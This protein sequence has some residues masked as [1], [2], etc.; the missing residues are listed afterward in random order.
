[1]KIPSFLKKKRTY[2]ILAILILGGLWWQNSIRSGQ[3]GLYETEVVAQ[4]DLVRTV[5]VT[6]EMKP[7]QRI[8]LSFEV[9][10]KLARVEKKVGDSVK[11]GDVI[12][13]L[14][15]DDLIFTLRRAESA[16]AVAEA[17]LRLRE[18][19]ETTQSIRVSEADVQKAQAA[20]DKSLVDLENAKISTANAIKSAEL[21]VKTA[22]NNL[23]NT[24]T[25]NEQAITNAVT[26]LRLGLLA[27]LGPLQTALTD[28]DA[29]V[30]VD[31]TATNSS[32]KRL[33]GLTDTQSMA[34]AEISYRSA[35]TLKAT[36]DVAVKAL[37]DQSTQ[38]SILKASGDVKAAL[39]SMQTFLTDVQKVLSASI[40][41]A[42]LTET[43]LNTK[44]AT[45]D[46]DRT[47]ISTQKTS[48][49][50]FVQGVENAKL[51]R[52]SSSDQ[53]ESAY[54]TAVLNLDTARS[55]AETQIKN[56]NSAIAIS[57][58]SLESAQAAL[59]LKKSGPRSID[60]EPLR[61]ALTDARTAYEQAVSNL[62]KAQVIAP[63]EGVVSEIVPELGEQVAA[64]A[65]VIKMVGL[66]QYD[67]EVLLPEA[68]VAKVKAGQSAS[69]TLDAYGDA[70][71]FNGV[72]VSEDPDQT[73]VQDA[74]YYKSR[75]Q[76]DPR[77]DVE[78]KPGMTANVT[79]STAKAEKVF[80]ISMRA[81]RTD[82]ASG[83]QTVR[84][85][86]GK[87]PVEK[88]VTLGLRG[89]EG[90]VEVMSGLAE[91]QTVIVSEQ[92]K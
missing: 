70:T 14:G 72:V 57:K 69:V 45:I 7:A 37:N 65:S 68:D 16:V 29:I 20:Y 88:V 90:K 12:A 21:A 53:L 63:V 82:S 33:L 87:N 79:I 34:T 44:K 2:V 30:G 64:G 86:D 28:G 15:D 35:K 74:V 52:N 71:T 41:G 17:N 61:A 8:E 46:G 66:A 51:G 54:D 47:V 23:A 27:T 78:F 9:S 50:T 73:V 59:D 81:V 85:L 25:T 13:Q 6:G 55:E 89:D 18:A 84:I 40:A 24:G 43:Q 38:E 3:E 11:P 39:L 83:V 77:E 26:N 36:A 32:Y 67:I 62:K 31:D 75:I 76:L 19:G 1:M 42:A 49:E 80:V 60:L 56:A 91:G 4:R 92:S 22:E 58:A 48:V 5:E 10:G